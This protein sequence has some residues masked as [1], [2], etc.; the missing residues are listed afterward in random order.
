MTEQANPQPGADLHTAAER[1][2]KLDQP[3]ET[4]TQTEPE[5]AKP[6]QEVKQE[7]KQQETPEQETQEASSEPQEAETEEEQIQFETLSQFADALDMPFDDFLGNIKTTIKVA[8]AERDVTLS[9]LRDGYQMEA[10][11]RRKTSELAEKRKEFDAER[12]HLT[13]ELNTQF[14]EA[15]NLTG[16]L[17]QSLLAEFQAVDWNGLR[18]SDPAE[19]AARKQEFNDRHA[20]IQQARN[21][22]NDEIRKQYTE[23]Q[24]EQKEK[25]KQIL[26]GEKEKLIDAIPDFGN[27]EK[28]KALTA[29]ISD[30]LK[31]QGFND[32]EID[33]IYDHRHLLVIR[34]AMA[35]RELKTRQ[36]EVKNKVV[37][38]PKLQKPGSG[39]KPSGEKVRQQLRSRLKKSGRVEDAAAL[40][41][42]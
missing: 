23:Q 2:S 12:E 1:I 32:G 33:Q 26:E 35:Y 40:I 7:V 42:L 18:Q 30:Y 9:E 37:N 41:K 34:D 5:Q 10:D 22:I 13:N 3:Q 36:P 20:Q 17:E 8:G 15:Q 38:A 28:A 4:E 25:Y 21:Q 14:K 24:D 39:Q 11:Y 16:L 19:F 6:E 31:A 29:N 27:E